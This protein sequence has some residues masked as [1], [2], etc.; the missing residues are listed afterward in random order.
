[1]WHYAE[2]R[3][4]R[5][6]WDRIAWR[7][8]AGISTSAETV[9]AAQ[10]EAGKRCAREG[11]G[12]HTF[13]C[14][15]AGGKVGGKIGGKEIHRKKNEE[16]KSEHGVRCAELLHS[17]KNDQGKSVIAVESMGKLHAEKTDEGKSMHALRCLQKIHSVKDENGK[18]VVGVKVAKNTNNQ[19]WMCL[20]TGYVSNP[21]ALSRYQQKRGLSIGSENRVKL[22]KRD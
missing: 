15:S 12:F 5:D 2:W 17:T 1:M 16:G 10:T 6:E 21:G 7:G 14:R 19:E 20:T 9:K 8:L 13:E 3:L 11:L 22:E 4:N 18:S